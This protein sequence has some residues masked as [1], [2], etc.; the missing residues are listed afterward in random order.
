MSLVFSLIGFFY[1]KHG[2]RVVDMKFAIAGILLVIF[3][4][5]TPTI[6]WTIGVGVLLC[7]AP[8]IPMGQKPL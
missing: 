3:G 7:A 1:L 2:K 8:F 5:F 6:A 4:Y